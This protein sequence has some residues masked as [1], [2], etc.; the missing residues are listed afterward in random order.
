M[1]IATRYD[2]PGVQRRLRSFH[3]QWTS[4]PF[5]F[6]F[7]Y[8]VLIIFKS[9]NET[10]DR[11]LLYIWT[12]EAKYYFYSGTVMPGEAEIFQCVIRALV[13]YHSRLSDTWKLLNSDFYSV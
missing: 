1:T 13:R 3:G 5:V 9:T 8:K 6:Y 10:P 7:L 12:L 4:V 2:I 11:R